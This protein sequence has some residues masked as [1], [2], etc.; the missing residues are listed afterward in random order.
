[1]RIVKSFDI[2]ETLVTRPFAPPH[3][4]FPLVAKVA[5]RNRDLPIDP[6]TFEDA[7]IL[8][9]KKVRKKARKP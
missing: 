6:S 5:Q 1:M 9:E 3:K 8:A 7:R 4:L 2:F